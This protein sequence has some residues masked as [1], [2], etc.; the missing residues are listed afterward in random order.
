MKVITIAIVLALFPLSA[1]GD[2]A[3]PSPAPTEACFT[4]GAGCESPTVAHIDAATRSIWVQ[5]YS[6][7]SGPIAAALVRAHQRHVD[8]RVILDRSDATGH[9]S[10]LGVLLAAGVP[11]WIDARHAIAHNKV[12]VL[13]NAVVQTGSFN[14]TN[15]AEHSNAENAV[16]IADPGIAKLYADNWARHLAHSEPAA[17]APVATK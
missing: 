15:A 1:H 2:P 7:T 4:P 12:I 8:V 13:D 3:C 14:F 10:K 17:A 5:A 16:F 9:G 6:F 11:T